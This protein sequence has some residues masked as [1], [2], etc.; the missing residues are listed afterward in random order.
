MSYLAT[1]LNNVVDKSSGKAERVEEGR[2]G[3]VRVN[4]HFRC[5]TFQRGRKKIPREDEGMEEGRVC[6][7]QPCG[8]RGKS[9]VS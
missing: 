2:A 1:E 6:N 9:G 7:L 4:A 5:V 8:A 3:N